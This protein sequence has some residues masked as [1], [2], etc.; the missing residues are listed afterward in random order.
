MTVSPPR[1][2]VHLPRMGPEQQTSYSLHSLGPWLFL[3]SLPSKAFCTHVFLQWLWTLWISCSQHLLA[4]SL[5]AVCE[6]PIYSTL[7]GWC[8]QGKGTW[9]CFWVSIRSCYCYGAGVP[10]L[11]IAWTKPSHRCPAL[12]L[13]P[14]LSGDIP[15]PTLN[16]GGSIFIF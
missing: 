2:P 1:W 8:M 14:S 16:H 11:T 3:V 9:C 5:L 13:T 15:G 4:V 6:E 7:C 12:S 10:L